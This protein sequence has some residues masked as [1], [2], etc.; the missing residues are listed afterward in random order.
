MKAKLLS[1]SI[2][3]LLFAACSVPKDVA[4]FQGVD[5]LTPVQ[6]EQMNQVYSS[7]ICPDDLLTITVT[8]WDPSAV[9]PFNPP[10]YSY[11]IQGEVNVGSASQLHTY[12][13]DPEGYI[14]FPVLGKM[15]IIGL[16]K[17][18]F[19]DLLQ[20]KIAKYVKDPIVNVQIVNYKV[21]LMGEVVRPGTINIRNDRLSIIDAIGQAGDLTINANRKNIMIIREINGKKE[22]GR[23]DV[24]DP[25]LFASPYYFLRQNDVV[26]IEPNNAKKRNANY[27]QAQQYNLTIFATLMSTVSVISSIIIASTRK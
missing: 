16:S 5:Q 6:I 15:Q 12:L 3:L 1:F 18:E 17:Q 23:I 27:S 11:A 4:Y 14:N 22:F 13:V 24:T 2:S 10:V 26:Y 19:S 21:T 25:A 8:A 7:K 9:T 20:N